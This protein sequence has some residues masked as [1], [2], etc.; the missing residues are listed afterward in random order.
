[1]ATEL[2][3][4]QFKKIL[5]DKDITKPEDLAL[6]Q[7]IY[8]FDG[9][10]AYASQVGRILGYT[11]KT[12]HSPINLQIGRLA[13]RIA[14]KHDIE[15]TVRQNQKYKFWDI[16]FGGWEEGR[17]WV[18]QLKPNLKVAL[19][20]TDLTGENQYS[21]EIPTEYLDKL[22]E[23]AKRTVTVNSYERNPIARKFCI[24][25][26]GT[27]CSVCEFNFETEYGEIGKGY[28]HVHHLMPI[29][30]IGKTYEIDPI[31]DLRPVCPNCHSMLHRNKDTL[32]IAE[33]KTYYSEAKRQT[34][35]SRRGVIR[36]RG[37]VQC[38]RK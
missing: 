19:E 38:E 26:Y 12:P 29:S 8:S 6:F 2:T 18:W 30:E 25:H 28:I 32:T 4:D 34:K 23:G 16:F 9:H 31:K 22:S 24:E 15:F 10:K 33:L 37:T 21:E 13:K 27:V 36:Q 35:T 3:K 20:E 17:F 7:T 5:Q 1:M 11:G 14:K